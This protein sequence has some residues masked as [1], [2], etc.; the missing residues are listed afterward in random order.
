MVYTY[1][2]ASPLKQFGSANVM[3]LCEQEYI[4]ARVRKC[5]SMY[6]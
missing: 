5:Y 2:F 4:R 1:H 3:L 6:I